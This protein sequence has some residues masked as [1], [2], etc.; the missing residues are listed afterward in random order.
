M[1]LPDIVDV[2]PIYSPEH[3]GAISFADVLS[4]AERIC[5]LDDIKRHLH[6]F[7]ENHQ[8]YKSARQEA[9]MLYLGEY[10]VRNKEDIII[11][12][13]QSLKDRFIPWY[14]RLGNAA[15]FHPESNSLGIHRYRTSSIGITPHLEHK[16]CRNLVA[17]FVIEG[18]AP[19]LVGKERDRTNT[20]L[21]GSPGSLILMRAPRNDDELQYR[22]FHCVDT[23]REERYAIIFRQLQ[24]P[25]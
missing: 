3:I 14:G 17:S 23:V 7:K 2:L 21:E 24:E 13:V 5:L 9:E 18:D 6:L 25:M 12:A 1:N 20:R 11:P 22:P 16:F 19:F 4:T 8:V 15:G 10:D